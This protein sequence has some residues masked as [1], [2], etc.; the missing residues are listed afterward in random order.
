MS[1]AS[2]DT[3]Q[4]VIDA[5]VIDAISNNEDCDIDVTDYV[6]SVPCGPC[7]HLDFSPTLTSTSKTGVTKIDGE[8][9]IM[10]GGTPSGL[11]YNYKTFKR[12]LNRLST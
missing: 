6:I 8:Q 4:L 12:V 11:L 1:S 9:E 5:T 3:S 10:G 7:L 2:G